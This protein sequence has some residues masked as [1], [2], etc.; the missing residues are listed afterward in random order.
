MHAVLVTVSIKAG[1]DEE[2]QAQLETNVVP[3]VKQTP[4][5]VSAYW[6]RSGDGE[7][8]FSLAVFED[9]K[10]AQAAADNIPNVPRPDFIIFDNIEVREVVAHI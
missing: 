5:V 3:M 2:A 7:H 1:H 8:G 10:T 4:G 6:T 9:E